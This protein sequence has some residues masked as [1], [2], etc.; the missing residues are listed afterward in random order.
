MTV[1]EHNEKLIL[2]KAQLQ[3]QLMAQQNQL[4]LIL[5][6]MM[7][8]MKRKSVTLKPENLTLPGV[9]LHTHENGSIEIRFQ[10]KATPNGEA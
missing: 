6:A 10:D 1:A 4:G 2:E 7:R 5:A 9:H 3:H 8:Q